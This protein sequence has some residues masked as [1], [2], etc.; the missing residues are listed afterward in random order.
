MPARQRATVSPSLVD[1]VLA[2]V[3]H[4]EADSDTHDDLLADGGAAFAERAALVRV[5]R[6]R[7]PYPAEAGDRYRG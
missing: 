3:D 5:E 2:D 7:A 1:F 4:D 6:L